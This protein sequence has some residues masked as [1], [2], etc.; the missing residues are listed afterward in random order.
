MTTALHRNGTEARSRF[1]R[2]PL[3]LAPVTL[4]FKGDYAGIIINFDV[5]AV[6]A[7]L[8]DDAAGLRALTADLDA[9]ET[10]LDADATLDDAARASRRDALWLEGA[11]RVIARTVASVEWPYDEPPPDPAQ[12]DQWPFDPLILLWIAQNGLPLAGAQFAGP[13]AQQATRHTFL[14]TLAS[15]RTPPR[16]S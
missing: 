7:L 3:L 13:F 12:P 6:R 11:H 5:S 16:A 9:Q 8:D 15:L 14:S 4:P 2:T 10:A 1:P